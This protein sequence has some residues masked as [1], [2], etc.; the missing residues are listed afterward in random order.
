MVF[1]RLEV[2][3][4][5]FWVGIGVLLVMA[6]LLQWEAADKEDLDKRIDK[7][8]GPAVMRTL[9]ISIGILIIVI[10]IAAFLRKTL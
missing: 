5:L 4:V 6:G 7:M 8:L 2:I 9:K 3:G 10:G 1:E